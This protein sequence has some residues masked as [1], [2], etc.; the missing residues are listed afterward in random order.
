MARFAD[1]FLNGLAKCRVSGGV[2]KHVQI[3]RRGKERLVEI[4]GEALVIVF[5]DDP[6]RVTC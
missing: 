5:N 3:R 6:F 1:G 2:I 4:L